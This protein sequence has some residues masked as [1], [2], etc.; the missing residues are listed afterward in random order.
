VVGGPDQNDRYWDIRSDWPET[1]V[2][3]HML[4]ATNKFQ[5]VLQPA[6]DLNA[7]MLTLTAMQV[8][9]DTNDPFFTFLQPGAYAKH[10]PSG[11]PCDAAYHCFPPQLSQGGTIA[12]AV[13]ITV[14]GI[15]IAM[16]TCWY[17]ILLFWGDKLY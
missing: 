13:T 16:L 3:V 17:L 4:H 11:Q 7:P 6:L 15:G 2:S 9:N 1:E 10:K 12:L 14:V 8:I 5:S